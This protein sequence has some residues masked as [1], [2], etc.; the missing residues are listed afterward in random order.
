MSYLPHT[1]TQK[2]QMLAVLGKRSGEELF[3]DIP[4]SVRFPKLALP[5]ALS[6]PELVTLLAEY[7]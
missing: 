3:S 5:E 6:E 7:A 2:T 4:A 1:E